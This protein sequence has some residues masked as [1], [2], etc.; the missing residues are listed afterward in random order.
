MDTIA[1]DFETFYD[2][3]YSLSKMTT[4]AYVRDPRFEMILCSVKINAE[5]AFW[6]LED[7]LRHFLDNEIDIGEWAAIVHH[8]HF[9]GFILSHHFNKRPKRW[10]DTLSMARV[11]D[12]PKSGNSLDQ[13]LQ[14]HQVGIKGTYVTYAKGK[15]L[16]DFNAHELKDYGDYSNNDNE[17]AYALAT[18]IY[19]PLLPEHEFD[20]IDMTVR[21]FTEPVFL[22]NTAKLA[23]AVVSE[24]MRKIALLHR[25]GLICPRCKGSGVDPQMVAVVLGGDNSI[26]RQDE[27]CGTCGGWGVDK[28][29]IGS[30]EQLANMFR[31]AGVEPALKLSQATNPDGA[32]KY[33]YAFAKTDPAMQ[34]LLEDESEEVRVLAEARIG[35]KSNIIETRAARF[36]DC[37]TRG[38]M[39]VYIKH[40]AA[41]TRRVGGGDSMNWLNMSSENKNRP[42]MAVLKQSI[43]APPGHVIIDVDSGQG[44][45][46][47]LAYLAGQADLLEAFAQG[48]D[49]YSEYASDIYGRLVQRK[50]KVDGVLVDHVPG[51]LGKVS[52]LG[53]GF[54]MGWYKAAMELLKGMLGNDPIQF[55]QAH[56]EQFGIDPSRFLNSPKK[57]KQVSEMPSRLEMKD[58]FI[59]CIVADYLVQRYRKKYPHITGA[60]KNILGFWQ[61]MEQMIDAMIL[62]QE[63]SFGPNDMFVVSKERIDGPTGLWLDYKGIERDEHGQASYWDGRERTKIYGA[64]L[65]EN[66]VQHT[67]RLIVCEQAMEINK[68]LKVALLPYDAVTCI[69]PTEAAQPALEFMIQTI[70]TTPAWAPGLPLTA[71]GGIGLTYAD[72]K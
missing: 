2:N 34:A 16:A 65:T 49:V 18:R 22:G 7:R 42:E 44:E 13:C 67:H 15:R 10:I 72:A 38:T 9:D 66:I 54:G 33:I 31:A 71:E 12:G 45:A 52:I 70:S 23:D 50:V 20:L 21:M 51:Q 17:G 59:H 60:D 27:P 26:L 24:K 37:A 8:A 46:R 32:A 3:E 36:L 29:P 30:N 25:I 47:I 40:A 19:M 41:H 55:T 1:L 5:P 43:L 61:L 64:L 53:L 11:V 62:G 63:R 39:P 56:L 58:R 68:F 48:R 6:L 35:I 69:V 57:I 14:R 4:E 28:K